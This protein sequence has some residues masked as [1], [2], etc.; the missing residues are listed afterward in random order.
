MTKKS[1]LIGPSGKRLLMAE[2]GNDN[3]DSV[4]CKEVDSSASCSLKIL[5]FY[6][7]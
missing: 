7:V 2:R 6:Y 1:R 3:E 5:A 4:E